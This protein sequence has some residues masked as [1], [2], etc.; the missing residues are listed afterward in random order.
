MALYRVVAGRFGSGKQ[1]GVGDI[2]EIDPA[3][4]VGFEDKLQPVAEGAAVAEGAEV[5]AVAPERKAK[6]K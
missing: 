6:A 5:T 2:V 1:F 4:T 3:H